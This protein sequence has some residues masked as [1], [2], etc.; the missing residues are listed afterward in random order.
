[1]DLSSEKT[2]KIIEFV[3]GE[4]AFT[5]R[6]LSRELAVS[7]GQV[8]KVINWLKLK[9][10]VKKEGNS[11]RLSD[12]AG[13]VTAISF[14][15]H[16]GQL[17][18]L[19]ISLGLGKNEAFARLPKEAIL[20][21]ESAQDFFSPNFAS[22]RLCVYAGEKTAKKISEAFAGFEGNQ[23]Q[24][25]AFRPIPAVKP[26][27]KG[28]RLLTSKVRTVIDLVCDDKAFAADPLFRQLWGSKLG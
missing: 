5:Q 28:N 15:R 19:T 25:L 22:N 18:I 6:R 12:P 17:K 23:T 4:K 26:V 20:C 1:M 27:K 2:F 11:F 7:I 16:M 13:I 3:L 10:F 8:N 21:L 14:F 9:N 24:L